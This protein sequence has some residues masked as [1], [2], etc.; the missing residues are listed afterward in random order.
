MRRLMMLVLAISFAGCISTEAPE[1]IG[2]IEQ[3][4]HGAGEV[5]TLCTHNGIRA[6]CRVVL[7]NAATGEMVF[8]G[9]SEGTASH[10]PAGDY[11]ATF[12][13]RASD[14]L[15]PVGRSIRVT[16]VQHMVSTASMNFD[17]GVLSPYLRVNGI[18]QRSRAT[19][20][21]PGGSVRVVTNDGRTPRYVVL[22]GNYS[23]SIEG[24]TG[25][26]VVPRPDGL[27]R[28]ALERPGQRLAPRFD[29]RVP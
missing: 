9:D 1:E 13:L 28:I 3:A 20:T 23:I 6:S 18:T 24:C 21:Y 8:S 14:L 11:D 29:C 2:A 12:T 4:E 22:L 7:V 26:L 10:I 19:I 25:R 16:V 17:T 27:H 5:A 15:L